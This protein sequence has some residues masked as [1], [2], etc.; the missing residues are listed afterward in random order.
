MLKILFAGFR[1]GHI[2]A[3][4]KKALESTDCVIAGCYEENETARKAAEENLGAV[5]EN[6][7]Y[8][9]WL[10]S[11]IDAVAVGDAYGKR[12]N[13][14]I[15]A[16][17]AGKH[18]ITDKPV[19]ID[20]S[21]LLE[22]EKICKET[23]LKLGCMLD[24]RDLPQV[25]KAEEILKS[26]KLGEVRNVAFNGQH[27]I[28]YANRPAWYFEEG[29]HGGTINDLSIHGVDLVRRLSGMEITKID[30]AR[31]WNSY[32]YKN[33]DFK[34]SAMF[35]ARLSN[36]AGVLA[37]ISYSAPSQV[38]SLP[39]Y[40][41]FRFWCEKGVLYLS[42]NDPEITVYEEGILEPQ[43]FEG[44]IDDRDYLSNFVK[45]VADNDNTLTEEVIKSTRT[46]LMLQSAAD[47]LKD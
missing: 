31:V 24:L 43:K 35:M 2:N 5:F 7:S 1:H 27:C 15:K 14:I 30:A 26:G 3:L 18:I 28:D 25:K 16:L 47:N 13:I 6:K 21:D 8:D 4:Y 33:K 42:L 20:E 9:E 41:E 36:G 11:D 45:A 12:G 44:I 38:F 32:A 17:K 46:A 40:W 37:D 22:I 19:C 10:L 34:D 29:M 23:G 39:T